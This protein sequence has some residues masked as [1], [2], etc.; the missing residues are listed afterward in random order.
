[1]AGSRLGVW[2]GP[3]GDVAGNLVEATRRTAPASDWERLLELPDVL[4]PSPA[5]AGGDPGVPSLRRGLRALGAASRCPRAVV[6]LGNA[7][8]QDALGAVTGGCAARLL[9]RAPGSSSRTFRLAW[10]ALQEG[11][12]VAWSHDALSSA[13]PPPRALC[14]LAG[15]LGVP[16]AV[17]DRG[18]ASLAWELRLLDAAARAGWGGVQAWLGTGTSDTDRLGALASALRP[19]QVH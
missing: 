1:M 5:P 12:P 15:E 10:A 9:G 13:Q 4:V 11:H 17:L 8:E 3:D 2:V 6:L 14:L 19:A 18:G 16:L 7:P